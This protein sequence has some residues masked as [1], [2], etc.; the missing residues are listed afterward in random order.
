MQFFADEDD[1]PLLLTRLNEDPELAV[2]VRDDPAPILTKSWFDPVDEGLDDIHRHRQPQRDSSCEAGV[3]K[4]G[5]GD[6]RLWHFAG[7]SLSPE[8]DGI[9]PGD[10]P[11]AGWVVPVEEMPRVARL[12][13]VPSSVVHLQL[14]SR[15]RPYSEQELRVN[16][17]KPLSIAA[18]T[19]RGEGPQSAAA[20]RPAGS[21][22][23]QLGSPLLVSLEA[24]SLRTHP[25]RAASV[26]LRPRGGFLRGSPLPEINDIRSA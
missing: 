9:G 22:W 26:G 11:W 15:H 12:G 3:P 21:N 2:I 5:D 6:N 23:R 13:A 14:W 10:D 18:L 20:S 17:A 25:S 16:G 7:Y 8:R 24:A 19:R 1:V 4:F